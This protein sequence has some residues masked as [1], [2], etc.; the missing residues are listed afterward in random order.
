MV[1]SDVN[2]RY[3]FNH[4]LNYCISQSRSG[5]KSMRILKGVRK[6]IEE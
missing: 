2:E 1:I 6:Y 4:R 3:T 5:L